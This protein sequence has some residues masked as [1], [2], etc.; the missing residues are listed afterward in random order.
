MAKLDSLFIPPGVTI[1]W[2]GLPFLL[3]IG[4]SVLGD[5]ESYKLA[6][7]MEDREATEESIS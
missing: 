4:A 5:E 2:Q 7:R 1:H 3:S 6:K